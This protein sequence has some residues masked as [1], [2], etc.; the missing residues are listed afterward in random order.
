MA[1]N[2]YT[3]NNQYGTNILCVWQWKCLK[4]C[5]KKM[6][7]NNPL[8]PST[9]HSHEITTIS[10]QQ[11][12]NQ[13]LMDKIWSYIWEAVPFRYCIYILV[14]K[15]GN[16]NFHFIPTLND[17]LKMIFNDWIIRFSPNVWQIGTP[18]YCATAPPQT[19]GPCS[20][21]VRLTCA[22]SRC[23]QWRTPSTWWVATRTS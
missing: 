19:H 10:K 1:D 2:G 13:F 8:S 9:C 18:M 7:D 17:Y 15:K 21:P 20:V 22:S 5:T 12:F 23:S 3:A 14:G 4:N 6:L 11:R 16:C